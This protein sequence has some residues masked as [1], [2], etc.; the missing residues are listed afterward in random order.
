[1]HGYDV[2]DHQQVNSEL[3]GSQGHRQFCKSLGD[4]GLG[5]ILD[6][7]PNH[8]AIGSLNRFWWD[9]LEDGADSRYASFFDIDWTPHE[10]RLRDKVLV[11]ILGE[12]YGLALEA[13]GIRVL[14]EGAKF[15]VE[16][17]GQFLPVS[18]RSL[19][20]IL[21]KAALNSGSAL[22]GF[23]SDSYLRLPSPS[24]E[25]RRTTLARQRDKAVI[26]T[27][28]EKAYVEDGAV[29]ESMNRALRELN[30]DHDALDAFLNEQNYRLA[31]WKTADQ[32]LGYRRFFDVNSL[33]GLRMERPH[34]FDETHAL[35]LDW[36]SR[37]VLDG[38]RIDHPDGLRN[39]LEYFRRLRE[40]APQA[41]IIGEK[42]L[43]PGEFLRSGKRAAW[44]IDGT[45][46]YDFLN[47][48]LGLLI[49]RNGM[50]TLTEIYSEFTHEPTEF[51]PI[52]HD[53][54]IAVAQEGLGSDVNSLTSIFVNICESHRNQR[55]YTR[56]E[57]RRA[58][59]EIA[60]CFDIYR[61]YVV[62]PEKD[63]AGEIV[64]EDRRHLTHA[65]DLAR[66]QRFRN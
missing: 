1:M 39:P 26:E 23:L 30:V 16:V 66:V 44:P 18:P 64:A 40:A 45:S 59:R 57:I 19:P 33:I 21:S 63:R 5:Q 10:E 41:W 34:V 58:I 6:I 49:K 17:S 9:V 53:K 37:G 31:Y 65:I 35:I 48:A 20:A 51:A 28:L 43:A 56:P 61:T 62:P 11:P 55:D 15:K 24:F 38:L 2:I 13:G 8:M 36:L 3:G 14:R 32:E 60:A 50:E 46:G 27:L 4:N 54:R 25:D 52:A 29:K 12:Q 42:I 47:T 7:V 22:L